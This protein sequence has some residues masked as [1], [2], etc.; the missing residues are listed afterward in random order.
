MTI[1]KPKVIIIR[2]KGVSL[3]EDLAK[4]TASTW[5]EVGYETEFFDAIT[6]EDL[7]SYNYL[8]FGDKILS[9]RAGHRSLHN[10][11]NPI[12]NIEEGKWFRRELSTSEQA[13][14]YSHLEVLKL[15][16]KRGEPHFVVEHDG[17]L[18]GDRNDIVKLLKYCQ[19]DMSY[20]QLSHMI[21]RGAYWHPNMAKNVLNFVDEYNLGIRKRPVE[22]FNAYDLHG[23]CLQNA[24]GWMTTL[25]VYLIRSNNLYR[26]CII[27]SGSLV[28]DASF[29][30]NF[31]ASNSDSPWIIIDRSSWPGVIDHRNFKEVEQKVAVMVSGNYH[32]FLDVKDLKRSLWNIKVNFKNCDIFYQTWDTPRQREIFESI[33]ANV[34]FVPLPKLNT[35]KYDPRTVLINKYPERSSEDWNKNQLRALAMHKRDLEKG[36]K[37][38][39]D[40]HNGVLQ[41]L[42]FA[43]QWKRIPKGYDY[44]VRTRWDLHTGSCDSTRFKDMLHFAKDRVVG[45][46]FQAGKL[47][48]AIRRPSLNQRRAAHGEEGYFRGVQILRN[49]IR[50]W[51]NKGIYCIVENNG[52][53]KEAVEEMRLQG[54]RWE[55]TLND[56]AIIFKE[57]DMEGVDIEKLYNDG[58]LLHAEWGWHQIFCQKR[59]HVNIDGIFCIRRNCD[60]TRKTYNR[61]KSSRG[62]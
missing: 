35:E 1:D 53:N 59:T 28:R 38:K 33:D 29:K 21:L 4:N 31:I 37:T 41:H 51:V 44:Y 25:L 16:V 45:I 49:R 32:E 27:A 30:Q 47:H 61:L 40:N 42:S 50:D 14:Y 55:D 7:D 8:D 43:E 62:V 36:R 2:N 18:V 15:I 13:V 58:K 10:W 26:R 19:S 39:C 52:L 17:G 20:V 54:Q 5:E 9:N 48:L 34:E 46:A 60:A 22:G 11:W 23:H 12:K 6:P 56:F 57:S 3:S 24:D